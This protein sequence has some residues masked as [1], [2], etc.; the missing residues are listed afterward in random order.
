MRRFVIAAL[1]AIL[2]AGAAMAQQQIPPIT[3]YGLRVDTGTKTATAVAGAATLNKASGFVTSKALT[4]AAAGTYVLTLTNST[5]A[6][7]D[8]VFTT[9]QLGTSTTGLPDVTSVKP[10][11]GS[12]VITVQNAGVTVFNGTI[13]LGFMVV[14]FP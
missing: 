8:L 3:L 10:G 4:T 1:A 6:A 12:V 14:K 9:V 5:I 2:F 11:A 7:T 13:K